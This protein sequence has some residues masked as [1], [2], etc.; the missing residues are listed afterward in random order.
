MKRFLRELKRRRVYPVAIAYTAVAWA[1][2]QVADVLL[3]TFNAP[4]WVMQVFTILLLLGFPVAMVLAWAFDFTSAGVVR[5]AEEEAESPG[6]DAAPV[7][8]GDARDLPS[9]PSIAVLP[10]RNL[11][12]D[13]EQDLFAEA[14]TGDITS[15]LT[16][17]SHLFVLTSGAT[18]AEDADDPDVVG[19]GRRL[20]VHYL[21][22]GSVRKAGDQLRVSVQLMDAR[23]GR[24]LWSENY[25][26][27]LTAE[28]LFA[29]QDD[30]REQIVAT[31]SDLHGVI[32][33]RHTQESVHRP[34]ASLNAYECLAVA[35]AYDKYLS[36][37]NHLRARESLERAVELDPE[38]DEAWAHLS[39]IYTDEH[40]FGYNPRPDSM[41][42]AL[43]AARK[44]IR[45]AP[46][47]YHNRWLLSRVYYFMGER[48]R[49]LAESRRA[50]ELNANDGTT[51]GLIGMYTAWCGLWEEGM[52]MMD[53][54][55]QLNPNFPDYYHLAAGVDR[56][57]H[58]DWEAARDETL[59][60]DL[61]DWLLNRVTLAAALAHCGETG[62]AREE[63]EAIE[64]LAPGFD[65]E[66]ADS[67][68]RQT[69]PFVPDLREKM[70]AGLRAA[71]LR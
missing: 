50:L 69:F 51:L 14:L 7:P 25:D 18:T 48:D 60:A 64:R 40:I 20:H 22:R 4:D 68:L 15:G 17:S 43:D 55:R 16:R 47:N 33:S 3:P 26:R 27:Q 23:E 53:K 58:G 46:R 67:F 1:V 45:L 44:S 62:R 49:F 66:F 71:G 35:L 65:G 28:S 19:L 13:T 36:E 41:E 38:Y 30:I 5:T 10:L 59:K 8:D 31:L 63:M 12:G 52:A 56:L 9:G 42:R 11:S 32:Y 2:L 39:W 57:A 70:L 29:V 24:E 61:P 54:A 34:T 6:D 37:E 21:L